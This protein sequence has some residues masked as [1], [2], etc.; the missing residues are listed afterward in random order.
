MTIVMPYA[1]NS[2]RK[3]ITSEEVSVFHASVGLSAKTQAD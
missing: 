1:F 2:V 3:F